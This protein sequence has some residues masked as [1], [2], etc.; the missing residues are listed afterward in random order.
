MELPGFTYLYNLAIISVTFTG[1]AALIALFRQLV[2]GRLVKYDVFFVHTILVRS[3]I[4]IA[5]ALLPPLLMLFDLSPTTIWRLSSLVGA[6]LIGVFTLS[7]PIIRRLATS[8]P[9][10]KV[11]RVYY[12]IQM[13]TVIFLLAVALGIFLEPLPSYFAASVTIFMLVNWIMVLQ[14]LDIMLHRP[15]RDRDRKQR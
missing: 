6:V 11:S 13:L 12:V 8:T 7:W 4:V 9:M 10:R 14:S 15:S 1:F 3:L 2:G 5:C